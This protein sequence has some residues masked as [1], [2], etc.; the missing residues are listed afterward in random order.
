VTIKVADQGNLRLASKDLAISIAP[1]AFPDL[2]I[3]VQALL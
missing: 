3:E 1:L 2:A